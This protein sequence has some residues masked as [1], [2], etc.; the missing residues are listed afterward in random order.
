MNIFLVVVVF[1]F[2][3]CLHA[4][5]DKH[6]LF[7]SDT[8]A[9][10]ALKLY[11]HCPWVLFIGSVLCPFSPASAVWCSELGS[12]LFFLQ[13]W[14]IFCSARWSFYISPAAYVEFVCLSFCHPQMQISD[15]RK[16]KEK[17]WTGGDSRE[18]PLNI[19]WWKTYLRGS[20]SSRGKQQTLPA[21][22]IF[23]FSSICHLQQST[24]LSSRRG[25]NTCAAVIN[26][27]EM[28]I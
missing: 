26:M 11:F 28:R 13:G 5:Q 15:A 19:C 3:K 14:G 8:E 20:A 24:P 16:R 21:S 22:P 27:R 4:R 2:L 1:F 10:S 18:Q 12:C 25:N 7:G 9:L 6:L 17:N 23:S